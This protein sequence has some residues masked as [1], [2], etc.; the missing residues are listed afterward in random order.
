[1]D[2][3]EEEDLEEV[4]QLLLDGPIEPSR[5]NFEY[6]S[7]GA[8]KGKTFLPLTFFALMISCGGTSSPLEVECPIEIELLEIVFAGD[9]EFMVGGLP[10][11]LTLPVVNPPPPPDA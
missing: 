7:K 9:L 11:P 1:L 10:Y 5:P 8:T 6:P 2:D 3:L 4:L